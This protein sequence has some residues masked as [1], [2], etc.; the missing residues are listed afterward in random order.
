MEIRK[1][2]SPER[3]RIYIFP[4]GDRVEFVHVTGLEVRPSGRHRVETA[5]GQKAIV[6]AHWLAIEIDVDAWTF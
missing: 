4:G 5:D 2:D 1:L 3:K 6:A